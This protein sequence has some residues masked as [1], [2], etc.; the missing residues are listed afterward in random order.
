[1]SRLTGVHPR[2]IFA[3]TKILNASAELGCPMMVTSGVRTTEQQQALYAKG[4]TEPGRIVTQADGV[5]KKSK[6]QA[7]YDGFGHAVDLTF[8]VD[9]R[10]SWAED[11]PWDLYG[12]MAKVLG[13]E[14]G[15]SWDGFVDRP[16][17]ELKP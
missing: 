6:H 10:P 3:V 8:M 11:H 14:W 17:V 9:G 1:M 5:R 7:Q 15:G 4:R 13:L 2:L 16:H 12:E